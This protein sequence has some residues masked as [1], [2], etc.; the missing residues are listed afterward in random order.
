MPPC[1][2]GTTRIDSGPDSKR[3]LEPLREALNPQLKTDWALEKV[4]DDN[5]RWNIGLAT[6]RKEQEGRKGD[7]TPT[8]VPQQ[9]KTA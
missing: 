9:R 7:A 6:L 3:K 4:K 8:K 5:G 2:N 1:F